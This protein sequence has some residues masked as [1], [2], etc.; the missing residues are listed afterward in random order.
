MTLERLNELPTDAAEAELLA[1]CGAR[2]WAVRM[3]RARPFADAEALYAEAERVW[4]SLTPED[5]L[6]AFRAHPRIGE[7]KPAAGATPGAASRTARWSE[8]EQ[9]GART[10]TADTLKRLAD[11][12]RAYEERFGHIFLICATGLSAVEMLRALERRMYSDA[13]TEL[14]VAAAEQAAITRLRLEKLLTP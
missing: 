12:S 5:W 1:C 9:A 10:A 6:E 2:A 7:R 3:A 11:G 8:Q 13:A 4:W 14:R